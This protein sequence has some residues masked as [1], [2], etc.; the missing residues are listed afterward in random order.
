MLKKLS[1]IAVLFFFVVLGMV[2]ALVVSINLLVESERESIE[3]FLQDSFSLDVNYRKAT[4][5]FIPRLALSLEKFVVINPKNLE[6][7]HL[8]S[9]SAKIEI[10]LLAL[11]VDQILI[12]RLSLENAVI[13]Y[14]KSDE[15]S[16]D[17]LSFGFLDKLISSVENFEIEDGRLILEKK[18]EDKFKEINHINLSSQVSADYG[19]IEFP[20]LELDFDYRQNKYR[21]DANDLKLELKANKLSASDLLVEVADGSLNFSDLVFENFKFKHFSLETKSLDLSLLGNLYGLFS[22]V[23]NELASQKGFLSSEFNAKRSA[24]DFSLVGQFDLQ[25][26]EIKSKQDYYK[27]ASIS[28]PIE[29]LI[30]EAADT[31]ISSSKLKAIGF[32]FS[33]EQTRLE[34][35]DMDMQ[36]L[37]VNIDANTDVSAKFYLKGSSLNLEAPSVQIFEIDSLTGPLTVEIPSTGG[38]LVQG[39]G[40]LEGGKLAV[41]DKALDQASADVDMYISRPKK[42]FKTTN[43]SYLFAGNMQSLSAS[44]QITPSIY[45]LNDASIAQGNGRFGINAQMMRGKEND[46]SFDIDV[47]NFDFKSILSFFVKEND[48]DEYTGILESLVAHAQGNKSSFLE[49]LNGYG[50]FRF[51]QG[52]IRNLNLSEKV[53]NVL[54][55]VKFINPMSKPKITD[56]EREQELK[57]VFRITEQ[58]VYFDELNISRNWYT[59]NGKGQLKFDLGLKIRARLVLLRETFKTLGLGIK[60]IEKLFEEL[61]AIEI[62]IMIDG[63]LPKIDVMPDLKEMAKRYSGISLLEY[64]WKGVKD[65]VR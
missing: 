26:Y 36:N 60:P 17:K 53:I 21:L 40:H 19:L 59:I 18:G 48:A 50:N 47:S 64:L 37:S 34:N 31:K 55:Q 43:L 4:V 27:A 14:Q 30:V 3:Y 45:E 24:S 7:P 20:R 56:D 15:K 52:I 41:F 65:V 6:K 29:L 8:I 54:E 38:Y 51:R 16:A 63:K 42:A 58:K 28:G 2:L 39:P 1:Q 12:D 25:N 10:D 62:P 11:F 5:K 13:I 32:A 61:G 44:L 46:F 22:S 35:V 49:S 23:S 57:G 33:D 9:E